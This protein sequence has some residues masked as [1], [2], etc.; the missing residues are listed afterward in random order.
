MNRPGG[1]PASDRARSANSPSGRVD[2][3]GLP[4]LTAGGRG[5]VEQV[6]EHVQ[7]PH[8]LGANSPRRPRGRGG[9][10]TKR[11]ERGQ[12]LE[13]MVEQL[14]QRTRGNF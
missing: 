2:G 5:G 7:A 3:D 10:I 12:M 6:V 4:A 14:R 9:S 8:P 11:V 1:Q 13:E